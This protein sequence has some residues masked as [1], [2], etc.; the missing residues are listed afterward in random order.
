[1]DNPKTFLYPIQVKLRTK[2]SPFAAK[3]LLKRIGLIEVVI[4]FVV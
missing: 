3:T 1:M 4:L 2:Y